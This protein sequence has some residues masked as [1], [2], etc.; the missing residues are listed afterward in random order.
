MIEGGKASEERIPLLLIL[1]VITTGNGKW[2]AS[3]RVR[4]F[5]KIDRLCFFGAIEREREIAR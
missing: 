4:A 2:R 3:E 1:L 5:C